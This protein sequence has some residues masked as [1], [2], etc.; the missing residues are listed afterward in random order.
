MRGEQFNGARMPTS[1]LGA[2]LSVSEETAARRGAAER[3]SAQLEQAIRRMFHNFERRHGLVA[4]EGQILQL[5]T[6]MNRLGAQR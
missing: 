1:P 3:S 5:D 4:G 6:G 2:P